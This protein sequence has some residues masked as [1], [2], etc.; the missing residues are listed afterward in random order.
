MKRLISKLK[1]SLGSLVCALVLIPVSGSSAHA[2][3][4]SQWDGDFTI[5]FLTSEFDGTNTSFFYSLCHPHASQARGF[6]H[7]V[8]GLCQS[9]DTSFVNGSCKV[10]A[11]PAACTVGVDPTT[12]VNGVKF[13][14]DD[15]GNIDEGECKVFSFAMSGNV[16]VGSISVSVK[17]GQCDNRETAVV[18]SLNN[19]LGVNPVNCPVDSISGPSCQLLPTPSPTPLPTE[20]PTS[21]PTE[22]P[23]ATSTVTATSTPTETPTAINTATATPTE[24]PFSTTT[25]TPTATSTP[26]ESPTAT[27]TA[28]ATPTQVATETPTAVPTE[29]PIVLVCNAGAAQPNIACASDP[30]SAD[31]DGSGSSAPEGFTLSYSWTSDCP[32]AQ[33]DDANAVKP[34]VNFNSL[35]NNNTPVSCSVFLTI[36]AN[37]V[38]DEFRSEEFEQPEPISATCSAVLGVGPCIFD[39][40]GKLNGQSAFDRCGVCNGDGNG[41]L[42]CTDLNITPQLFILDGNANGQ[43]KIVDKLARAV[44]K[45]P[46]ATSGQKS[47]ARAA[48]LN[49]QKLY[50][51]S[52]HKVWEGIPQIVTSCAN[53]TFCAQIDNGTTIDSFL[54]NS[55]ALKNLAVKTERLLRKLSGSKR[56]GAG[57]LS[58]AQKLDAQNKSTAAGVPRFNTACTTA[59]QQIS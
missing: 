57:L 41:C 12:Q 52:W 59:S 16:G 46:G 58:K 53:Q 39:C 18:D 29:T 8:F 2:V 56:T 28:T 27:E 9:N 19:T 4:I 1:L 21:T 44:L 7:I 24:T 42:G 15:I 10:N 48:I 51:D 45:F 50:Q 36:T 6:S 35:N 31:L 25:S 22:T 49:A 26:T 5:E 13:E 30:V 38:I 23:T 11:L 34:K 47:Q 3:P 20:T 55:S 32:G 54:A 17:A 33:F 37:P 14:Q 43:S 40:T